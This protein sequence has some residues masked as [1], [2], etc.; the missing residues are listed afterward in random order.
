[1]SAESTWEQMQRLE[2]MIDEDQQKWDLSPNDIAA[3]Q[4]ALYLIH[5]YVPFEKLN[6]VSDEK[7]TA[8]V[9]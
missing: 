9:E 1:M 3:I 8:R 2:M 6:E 4:K 7:R 5:D